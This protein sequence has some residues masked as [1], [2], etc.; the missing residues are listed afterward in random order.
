VVVEPNRGTIVSDPKDKQENASAAGW[1][2]EVSRID[3]VEPGRVR[4][5]RD[6]FHR[7]HVQVSGEAEH[8]DVRPAHVFPISG[9]ANCIS[10]LDRDDKEVLLLK[11]TSELDPESGQVLEEEIGRTYFVPNITYVY[12]IEDSHG[13][14]RW[15]VETDRGYRVFDVRDRED[16]RVIQGK[17]VLLQDAD[18]NRFEIKDLSLLDPQSQKLVDNEI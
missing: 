16:V 6:E 14:A 12:E 2:A 4:I 5:W 8:V 18:G 13:A 7:L 1:D 15:E 9:A 3:M 10:F 11:G 17:R